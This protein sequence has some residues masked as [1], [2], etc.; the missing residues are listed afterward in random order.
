MEKDASK[1]DHEARLAQ[2]RP[3]RMPIGSQGL[4]CHQ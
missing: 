3:E 1:P 2:N 4:I